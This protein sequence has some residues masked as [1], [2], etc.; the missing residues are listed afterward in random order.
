MMLLFALFD[1]KRENPEPNYPNKNQS[2]PIK[3]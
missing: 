1:E 3:H 2:H